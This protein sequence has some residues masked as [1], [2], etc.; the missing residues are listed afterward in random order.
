MVLGLE[1][2]VFQEDKL[3]G[4]GWKN[5]EAMEAGKV[6]GGGLRAT[7]AP[8]GKRW[9]RRG[10]MVKKREEIE[11]Q[12]MVHIAVERNRRKQ[13]NEYL[14]VLRSMMPSSYTQRGDQASIVGGTIKFVKELEQLVQWLEG[15]KQRHEHICYSGQDYSGESKVEVRVIE[16]YANIKMRAENRPK[17]LLKVA[18]ELHSLQLLI[19]H[20]NVTTIRQM[21]FY[22]FSVKIEDECELNTVGEITA[23]VNQMFQR[24]L[25]EKGD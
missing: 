8:V 20:V 13:M 15:K 14:C 18:L 11:K 7:V 19:L 2:A 1:S 16:R 9:G 17:Q 3:I 10:K 12:R 5:V 25:V 4:C 24:I 6:G 21:V 22:C 23:A